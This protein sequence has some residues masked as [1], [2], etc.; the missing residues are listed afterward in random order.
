MNNESAFLNCI[1]WS[2]PLLDQ[3]HIDDKFYL[4]H[5]AYYYNSL[6]SGIYNFKY[7]CIQIPEFEILDNNLLHDLDFDLINKHHIPILRRIVNDDKDYW[8]IDLTHYENHKLQ[9][10]DI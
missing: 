6:N 9:H 5:S 1:V 10:T 3:P 4:V 8:K 7:D 2:V